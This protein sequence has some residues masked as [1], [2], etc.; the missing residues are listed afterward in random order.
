M[1]G[2]TNISEDWD[3]SI[4]SY[5][6]TEILTAEIILNLRNPHHTMEINGSVP[7]RNEAFEK[8]QSEMMIR[9]YIQKYL[10]RMARLDECEKNFLHDNTFHNIDSGH[11]IAYK[12]KVGKN[13]ETMLVSKDGKRGY[14]FLLEFDKEDFG[15]GI[16]YGCRGLILDGDQE[17]QINRFIT[18]WEEC[19]LKEMVSTALGNTFD[20]IDFNDRFQLTTNANNR[21][22]WPFW[23]TL[24]ENEDIIEVGARATGLIGR[25][26]RD[27]IED[28]HRHIS[29]SPC[30]ISPKVNRTSAR[31]STKT[32]FTEAAYIG[33][34]DEIHKISR[35]ECLPEEKQVKIYE[36]FIRY[37]LERRFLVRDSRYELAYRFISDSDKAITNDEISFILTWVSRMVCPRSLKSIHWA[38][39]KP[40]FLSAS[41]QRLDSISK[42][43]SRFSVNNIS[44]E[45]KERKEKLEDKAEK[46][47]D[48]YMTEIDSLDV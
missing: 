47:L 1:S 15:Y 11:H 46:L 23:I 19:G 20:T 35:R 41:G 33:I 16:Y 2:A 48:D 22:F 4:N 27:F 7:N 40:V 30:S 18:E 44:T 12:Y 10:D 13:G 37:G 21:T 32:S 5:K 3:L 8:K 6:F 43:S 34:I 26:Y 42:A 39:F 28:N 31:I 25:V 38:L 29:E 24:Y 14:E 45:L 17:E 9:K 36:R